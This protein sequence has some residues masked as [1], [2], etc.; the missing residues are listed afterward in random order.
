MQDFMFGRMRAQEAAPEPYILYDKEKSLEEPRPE[1]MTL[2]DYEYFKSMYPARVKELQLHVE[3]VFDEMDYQGSP[4]YDEYPDRLMVE[5]LCRKVEERLE[6]DIAEPAP[7]AAVD[8]EDA[9]QMEIYEARPV[10]HLPSQP[11]MP[12]G[13]EAFKESDRGCQVWE[14]EAAPRL[15][16]E[17]EQIQ[18]MSD[19]RPGGPPPP[20][21]PGGPWGPP[22]PPPRPGNPWGPPPPPPRPGNPW[23]PPPPPPRPGNPWGPPPPPPRPGNPWGPPRP[24]GRA[25]L[26]DLIN[27]LLFGE[28]Q[29][30]RCRN[31]QC[32]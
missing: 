10:R 1:A 19:R 3:A 24:N 28:M 8:T 9:E 11:R 23:G 30:R 5:Q 17:E 6:K 29:H 26:G 13:P 12:Y 14:M 22:P 18:E 4:I 16:M 7:M 21:R 2:R 32:R 27:L 15:E 20:P 25:D 31:R